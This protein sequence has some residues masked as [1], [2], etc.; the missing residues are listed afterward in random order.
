M[1]IIRRTTDQQQT[2]YARDVLPRG[3]GL[4]REEFRQSF[5]SA[6]EGVGSSL[7]GPI[8]DRPLNPPNL[9]P[10]VSSPV[11]GTNLLPFVHFSSVS[12][13]PIWASGVE[14][15]ELFLVVAGSGSGVGARRDG[16]LERH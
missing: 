6:I 8:S 16:R 4:G 5:S 9:L 7:G 10:V 11:E 15:P 1:K 2:L 12:A 3:V 13:E 14:K